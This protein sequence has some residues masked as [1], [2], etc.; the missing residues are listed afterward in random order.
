MPLRARNAALSVLAVL[1]G[2]LPMVSAMTYKKTLIASLGAVALLL[3]AGET[4]AEPGPARG[5][6]VAPTRPAF[7][8]FP[9]H[10]GHRG[11]FFPGT[12]GV[13]YGLANEVREPVVEAPP[14]KLSDDLRYTCVLD[15][16]WDYVHRCPQFTTPR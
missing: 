10:H 4:F 15:I 5:A 13:F 12:G 9:R 8:S 2:N 14:P 3:A 1:L 16:P 7:P 6:G 11:G